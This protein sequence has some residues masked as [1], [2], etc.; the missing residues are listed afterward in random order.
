MTI[1]R[2]TAKLTT[3]A[4]QWWC[5]LVVIYTVLIFGLPANLLTMHAYHL[6]SLEYR[7]LLFAV[8]L[9]SMLVWLAAF[10]GYAAL[11]QYAQ[12]IHKTKEGPHFNQLATGC[13]WLAWSLPLPT[14][15]SLL[16]NTLADKSPGFRPTAIIIANYLSLLFPL[17]GFSLIGNTAR[18]LTRSA[19][20][21]F[22]LAGARLIM[23]LFLLAGVLYCYLTFHHFDLTSLTSTHNPYF[24]PVWLAVVSI[25]VPYLYAW[26]IGLLG[27]YE[28]VLFSKNVQG[29]LYRRA[30]AYVAVGLVA[31]IVSS[32]TLQYINGVVPA[33]SHLVLNYKLVAITLFRILGGT[34]FIILALGAKRLKKIEEI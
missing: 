11:R 5:A 18:D 24:L 26:F 7:V 22:S 2:Q 32:I 13:Y 23:L 34:G 19:K 6:S 17:V 33:V 31:V 28:I 20:L 12:S 16:L 21:S 15:A 8:A 3:P 25:T 10:W 9:P 29:L 27:A 14:I 4:V 1:A 30:L